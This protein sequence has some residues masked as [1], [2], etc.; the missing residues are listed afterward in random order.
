MDSSTASAKA[1]DF[2][3]NKSREELQAEASTF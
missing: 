1:Q 3:A 2:M